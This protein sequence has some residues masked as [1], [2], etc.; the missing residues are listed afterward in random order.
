MPTA[1]SEVLAKN[2][3]TLGMCGKWHMGDDD[4]PQYGFSYWSTV[5]GGGGTYRNA[6]FVK[7]G[8]KGVLNEYKTDAVG[9]SAVEFLDTVKDKPFYL[10]VPIVAF[11]LLQL[12]Q[13]AVKPEQSMKQVSG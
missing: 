5:P 8:K 4:K 2:G 10:L 1:G 6:E 13:L 12:L 3:Y 9:D 11:L 7:N